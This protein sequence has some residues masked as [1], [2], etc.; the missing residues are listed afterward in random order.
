MAFIISQSGGDGVKV[1]Q[2]QIFLGYV[3]YFSDLTLV[4]L[5]VPVYDKT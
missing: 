4:T 2:F 5:M 1:S 3:T